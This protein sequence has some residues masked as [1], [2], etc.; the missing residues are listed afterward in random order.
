[1]LSYALK[2][3][4]EKDK[5]MASKSLVGSSVSMTVR[6]KTRKVNILGQREDGRYSARVRNQGG[7]SVR[8]VASLTSQGWRFKATNPENLD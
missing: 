8:G 6:G 3:R 4:K 2:L 1:V 7:S 5:L